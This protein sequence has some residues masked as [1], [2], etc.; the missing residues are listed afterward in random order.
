MYALWF[1]SPHFAWQSL[2]S[3]YAGLGPR[4]E[5]CGRYVTRIAKAGFHSCKGLPT[6]HCDKH[7]LPGQKNKPGDVSIPRLINTMTYVE[8]LL[9]LYSVVLHMQLIKLIGNGDILQP[10]SD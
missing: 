3:R 9:N 6:E 7:T 1:P 10:Q 8:R 2:L 4:P 5:K